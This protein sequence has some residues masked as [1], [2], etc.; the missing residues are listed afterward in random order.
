MIF[1]DAGSSNKKSY[2]VSQTNYSGDFGT[3]DVLK[4]N[5]TFLLYKI[6]HRK[7]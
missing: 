2:C 7:F 1:S 5:G 3:K 6:W 4:A